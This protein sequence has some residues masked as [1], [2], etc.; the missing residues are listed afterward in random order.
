MVGGM[1]GHIKKGTVGGRAYA[2]YLEKCAAGDTGFGCYLE[3]HSG[4]LRFT[5]CVGG[6]AAESR[7]SDPAEFELALEGRD[8]FDGRLLKGFRDGQ[9]RFYELPI[10]DSK[11]LD[12]A[13]VLFE[14]VREA[15][16]RAQAA[17]ERAVMDYV[18]GRLQVRIREGGG[19]RRWVTPDEAMW[20]SAAHQTSREGDPELHRHLVLVNRVRVGDRWY[21]IDSVKL[22]GMYENIRSVYETTVYNDPRLVAAM[23]CHGMSLDANGNVPELGDAADV[24]SKR[25]DMI[26]RRLEELVEEWRGNPENRYREVRDGQGNVVG[27]TGYR[28]LGQPDEGTLGK[29]RQQAWADTRRA[30][31]EWN[32]R[33]DWE[34][35][36][37]EL[38]DAGYDLRESLAGRAVPVR[39]DWRAV[40]DADVEL[41][42][43]NAV[44]GLQSMHSAWSLEQLEVACYD[45]VRALNVTGT[46]ED[47]GAL[48]ARIG[49]RAKGLCGTLSDDPRARVRWARNLTTGA[50]VECET[51]I[52]GRLAARGAEDTGALPDVRDVA[53]RFALDAGQAGA[54]ATVCKADPLAVVEG[55]AG[56]GKTHMLRAVKAY[57]DGHGYRL[58]LVTPTRKAA[59]VAAGEVGAP[60][61][62]LMKLLEVYGWRRDGTDPLR[63]WRRLEPGR[64]DHRGNT[65][66]GV[67]DEWRMDERTML[68]VDEAGMVDQDQLRA[69]LH[70][71]DATGA[72]L[73]LV[74]DRQQLNAV[75]RGGALEMA[76]R[77]TGNVAVMDDVHRFADPGYAA[78][79]LRLRGHSRENAAGLARELLDRGM[80]SRHVSDELT[81]AAIARAWADNPR[82][83]VSTATNEQ[84]DMV[85]AAIQA[86]R[87]EAGQ[88]GRRHC[89]GMVDGQV[90]HEGDRIM[91][92][93]ND[94]DSGVANRQTF[95]VVAIDGRGV[96]VRDETRRDRRLT[97]D[98]VR[99][100]VQLGYAAT[101]YGVQGVTARDAIFWAA[102]GAAGADTYVALTRGR[103]TNRV[104]LTADSEG[105]ALETLTGVIGRD[106][107]DRGLEAARQAV[108]EIIDQQPEPEPEL[109]ERQERDLAVME[110]WAAEDIAALNAELEDAKA[111]EDAVHAAEA[112]V[113]KAGERLDRAH[114]ADREA[115]D[116]WDRTATPLKDSV[117]AAETRLDRAETTVT[118]QVRERLSMDVQA[119]QRAFQG[120]QDAGDELDAWHARVRQAGTKAQEAARGYLHG[121]SRYER[122]RAYRDVCNA[123]LDRLERTGIGRVRIDSI[124]GMPHWTIRKADRERL[125]QYVTVQRD[126]MDAELR[127]MDDMSAAFRE[128]W[129]LDWRDALGA[130]A[131]RVVDAAVEASPTVREARERL[132][133]AHDELRTS[134]TLREADAAMRAAHRSVQS[135]QRALEAAQAALDTLPRPGRP[136]E[137]VRAVLEEIGCRA[138]R[139]M[140]E[141]YAQLNRVYGDELASLKDGPDPAGSDW[142]GEK[143]IGSD[144]LAVAMDESSRKAVRVDVGDGGRYLE[145][146]VFRVECDPVDGMPH[147]VADTVLS[148]RGIAA[149]CTRQI[150]NYGGDPE[151]AADRIRDI[152]A[153]ELGTTVDNVAV[154]ES[155]IRELTATLGIDDRNWGYGVLADAGFA[156]G[157]DGLHAA[158]PSM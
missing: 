21:A 91:T 131:R 153:S 129:R 13:G 82:T 27:C 99:G 102:P 32:T 149:L 146:V 48:C 78:F 6:R 66:R 135:S 25:R 60:A 95:T 33:V 22:F 30:K 14:D 39:G 140:A 2:A 122:V 108:Q 156:P 142:W 44:S 12:V 49:A 8:P 152:I 3:A 29:L 85:N 88:L 11:N 86:M 134:P 36:N 62:T 40:T 46:R 110:R 121:A 115:T 130:G 112:E 89:R 1:R 133:S 157:Y 120:I 43:L 71:A 139:T 23:A 83:A 100:H 28:D 56:A 18:A 107:G 92:R 113:E 53:R 9:T 105:E 155:R 57:C 77:Y 19:R 31:G 64:T 65:Y 154:R 117:H 45:Q 123:D 151:F 132:R 4:G 5:R 26:N 94:R 67:P 15:R 104:Y 54:V 68:V 51:D 148:R 103:Y 118:T 10:N 79:T 150:N 76:E 141:R 87:L 63:A 80:V 72:R 158:G 137:A 106:K 34:A 55:A 70:V 90:I 128:R 35:W 138:A 41:C 127:S 52:R 59:Q 7:A 97:A 93:A 42:A 125:V 75:G 24:F 126:R 147:P 38:E 74:G 37:G 98:Y 109:T 50:V 84:A 58:A 61:D 101:T 17:G 145:A 114:M 73:T 96:T 144:T 124:D 119:V 69:L 81:V 20:F 16:E 111:M 136:V 47:M 143:L 116:E